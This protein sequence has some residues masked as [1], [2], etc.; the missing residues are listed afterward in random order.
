MSVQEN[1][2]LDEE[3]LATWDTHDPDRALALLSDD[4]VWR[5]VSIPEP[6]RDKTAIRQFIQG[7]FTAF[8]DLSTV[9]KN[10]V[11]TEDQVATEVRWTATNSG[12]MQMAPGAPV[13]PATGKQVTGQGAYFLRVRNG[14]VVE[15]HSY[16]DV[17][18]LMMQLGLIPPPGQGGS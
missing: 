9:W 11:V 3:F 12:P 18:G 16:P 17:V 5:D 14:Q 6:L 1:I 4:I 2:R 13:M 10:R 8:P 15:V 7:W